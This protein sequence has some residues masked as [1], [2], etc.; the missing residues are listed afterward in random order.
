MVVLASERRGT[1]V[2]M[3]PPAPGETDPIA[4]VKRDDL[5]ANYAPIPY[6]LHE[7]AVCDLRAAA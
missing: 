7:L 6:D 3:H 4:L 5:P 1:I 2:E